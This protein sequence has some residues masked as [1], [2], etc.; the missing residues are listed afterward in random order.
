MPETEKPTF[1]L[2]LTQA[3]RR[4]VAG[5]LPNLTPRLALDAKN[6][7]LQFTLPEIEKIA[8]AARVAVPRAETGME[9]NSLC[10]VVEAAERAIANSQGIARIPASER[11]YQFK[12]TL[13]ETDPPIWRRIQ[14]KD[15]TLDK[16]HERRAAEICEQ[17][18]A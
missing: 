18:R 5:L 8:Q 4:A 13:K 6:R 9:R 7:T 14:V 10:H 3:Q 17:G 12:I 1:P 11:L 2:R 16:L 15:G